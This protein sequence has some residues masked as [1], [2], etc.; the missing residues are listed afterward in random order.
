MTTIHT[1]RV[2]LTERTIADGETFTFDAFAS[3]GPATLAVHPAAGAT[4]TV[5]YTASSPARIA[6]GTA[7]WIPAAIGEDGVVSEP[8]A[9]ET[10]TPLT[11][12]RITATGGEVAVEIVQ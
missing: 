10:I 1:G 2:S 6:A 4:A 12:L 7:R 11:G 3:A 9:I 8:T 5:A